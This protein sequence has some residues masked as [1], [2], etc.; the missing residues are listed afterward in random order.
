MRGWGEGARIHVQL[1][2]AGGGAEGVS[3]V[4][5]GPKLDTA[6]GAKIDKWVIFKCTGVMHVIATRL[7]WTST[8]EGGVEAH[9]V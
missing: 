8:V 6:R 4:V 2:A 1:L 3:L 5:E 7:D 9:M